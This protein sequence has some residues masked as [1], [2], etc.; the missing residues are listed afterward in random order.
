MLES[1]S[2]S[3]EL[4]HF[5]D[6]IVHETWTFKPVGV[7]RIIGDPYL[8]NVHYKYP[9][10]MPEPVPPKFEKIEIEFQKSEI[11][12][13][14]YCPPNLYHRT[15]SPFSDGKVDK[16]GSCKYKITLDENG[17]FENISW[18]ECT[19]KAFEIHTIR[20]VSGLYS[21]VKNKVC[22]PN[23]NEVEKMHYRL[24]DEDANIIPE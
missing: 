11:V 10:K 24:M 15:S 18:I 2:N 3:K 16:S 17:L 13:Q 9:A 7:P 21:S 1:S 14:P 5:S 12:G 8:E 20:N 22:L 19:D 4:D 23:E 6:I